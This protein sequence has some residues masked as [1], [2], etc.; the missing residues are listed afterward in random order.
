MFRKRLMQKAISY[1]PI[2]A[3]ILARY[4]FDG[5]AN[6]SVGS[7]NGTA[8][9]ITYSSGIVGDCAVFDSSLNSKI[10]F[11]N[12]SIFSISNGFTDI[13]KSFTLLFNANSIGGMLLCKDG[14]GSIN[15]RDYRISIRQNDIQ[16]IT[17]AGGLMTIRGHNVG[18]AN[19]NTGQWYHIGLTYNGNGLNTGW[20]IYVDGV[21]GTYS[22]SGTKSGSFLTTKT[23]V[24]GYQNRSLASYFDGKMDE[25]IIWDAEL[26]PSEMA[27]LAA[28][29]LNGIEI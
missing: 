3:P 29:Q 20:E 17:I 7:Q 23:F 14:A 27:S 8:S 1:E 9:N 24:A 2:T 19:F 5:N 11:T 18:S 10:D 25:I 6:D 4:K 26:T 16:I 15:T 28:Q 21:N 22:R 12:S 13:P